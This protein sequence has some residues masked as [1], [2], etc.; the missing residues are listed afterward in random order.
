M[1]NINTFVLSGSSQKKFSLLL[2]GWP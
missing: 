1:K 2:G